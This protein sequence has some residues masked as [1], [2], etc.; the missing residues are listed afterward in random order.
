MSENISICNGE[1]SF[2]GELSVLLEIPKN[3][4]DAT[5]N[6]SN[7]EKIYE[8]YYNFILLYFLFYNIYLDLIKKLQ[9]KLMRM[10]RI[11]VNKVIHRQK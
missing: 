2:F 6:S 11:Q 5:K 9:K 3:Q 4:K 7:P 8:T 1:N 10:E